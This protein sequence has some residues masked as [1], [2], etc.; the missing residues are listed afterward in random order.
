MDG[1]TVCV[2]NIPEDGRVTGMN[3]CTKRIHHRW[4]GSSFLSN[5]RSQFCDLR[6]AIFSYL[7]LRIASTMNSVDLFLDED[8]GGSGV[9]PLLLPSGDDDF[10]T[11]H[12]GQLSFWQV[13][14][15]T[16]PDSTRIVHYTSYRSRL[17]VMCRGMF[18]IILPMSLALLL[19]DPGP[20]L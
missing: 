19:L 18:L 6:S 14:F 5:A 10:T 1:Q 15:I 16:T 13:W 2:E 3:S 8:L 7:Q 4:R 11:G 9:E 20:L 17:Q 12:P